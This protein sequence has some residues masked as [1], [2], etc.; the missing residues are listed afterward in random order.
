MWKARVVRSSEMSKVTREEMCREIG[1]ERWVSRF[2]EI[3]GSQTGENHCKIQFPGRDVIKRPRG[4]GTGEN[5]NAL[6][7]D[8]FVIM[9][10]KICLEW[11]WSAQ[12]CCLS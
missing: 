11:S 3:S 7:I 5:F 9:T 12:I 8:K 2:D 10:L 1:D 4:S 6:N